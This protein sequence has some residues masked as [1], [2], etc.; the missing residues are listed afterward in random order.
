MK[1]PGPGPLTV[2]KPGRHHLVVDHVGRRFQRADQKPQ[3]EQSNKT[4]DQ[5]QAGGGH[6]PQDQDSGIEIAGTDVIHQPAAGNLAEGIGPAE[7]RQ[8]PAHLHIVESQFLAHGGRGDGDVAAV[9]IGDDHTDEQHQHHHV[10]MTCGLVGQTLCHLAPLT[11]L[12]KIRLRDAI[13]ADAS[14]GRLPR[15]APPR[16]H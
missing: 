6:R 3:R 16:L 5:A 11:I 2:G 15:H 1:A 4:A 7:A 13:P 10:A 14:D 12:Q 9:Q 8:D